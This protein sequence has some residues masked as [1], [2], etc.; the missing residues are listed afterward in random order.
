MPVVGGENSKWQTLSISDACIWFSRALSS[1]P[2][3]CIAYLLR[4]N[5]SG[6][7]PGDP[8]SQKRE[9]P[10]LACL[11]DVVAVAV[12]EVHVV[13]V[14]AMCAADLYWAFL[15]LF[16]LLPLVLDPENDAYDR[17]AGADDWDDD[18]ND[19]LIGFA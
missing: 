17:D 16:L 10:R 18:T 12:V 14:S 15:L 13:V 3:V 19:N 11:V 4:I 5:D 2:V 1:A 8:S 9:P 6:E 7:E